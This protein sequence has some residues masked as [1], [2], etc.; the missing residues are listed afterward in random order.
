MYQNC[1]HSVSLRYTVARLYETKEMTMPLFCAPV[2]L[3][4]LGNSFFKM[5]F[6]TQLQIR[7]V[8]QNSLLT[9]MEPV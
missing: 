6:M 4:F 8:E 7:F 5:M 2:C 9:V 3:F 1:N